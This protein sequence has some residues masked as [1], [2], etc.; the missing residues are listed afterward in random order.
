MLVAF[1]ILMVTWVIVFIMALSSQKRK[2]EFKKI[3]FNQF[4]IVI[5][6]SMGLMILT[7]GLL[8]LMG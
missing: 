8:S 5:L 6:I 2:G 3:T 4:G 1:Y 7:I